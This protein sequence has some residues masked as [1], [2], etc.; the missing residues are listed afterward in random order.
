MLQEAT[1][2]K[3]VLLQEIRV[4]VQVQDQRR[5]RIIVEEVEAEDNI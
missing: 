3:V 2:S 1:T 5:L 4:L